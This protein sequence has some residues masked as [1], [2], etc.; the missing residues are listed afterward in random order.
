LTDPRSK[1]DSANPAQAPDALPAGALLRAAADGELA[2][3][4]DAAL[5]ARL[6]S[7]PQADDRIRFE[8]S[9]R[10]ACA[11]AM[12]APAAPAHLRSRI[13][14]VIAAD[15]DAP[16][17]S[18]AL[19]L[20]GSPRVAIPFFR[21][22]W[23]AA[24]AAA[25]LLLALIPASLWVRARGDQAQAQYRTELA[26]FLTEEHRQCGCSHQGGDAPEVTLLPPDQIPGAYRDL[27]DGTPTPDELHA[28]GLVLTA[29]TPCQLPGHTDALHLQYQ[30][31]DPSPEP[32]SAKHISL[33]VKEYTGRRVT[34][35]EGKTYS[36][37]C[38]SNP[39]GPAV[40]V[41]RV[42]TKAYFL[43]SECPVAQDRARQAL[44]AP[45]PTPSKP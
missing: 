6:S 18:P 21:R 11:R 26:G 23:F 38:P 12:S 13:L 41:W 19:K 40:L 4:Q 36:W 44:R 43:V 24:L 25:A 45:R 10:D 35:D 22:T 14:A 33:F 37:T 29:T 31:A 3:A 7:Y 9:L 32:G 15:R 2:P 1:P 17:E 5:R 30:T 28:H 39:G 16:R 27:V 42:G 20:A 8:R 34:L